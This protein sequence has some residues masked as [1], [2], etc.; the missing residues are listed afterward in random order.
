MPLQLKFYKKFL[1][2]NG[3]LAVDKDMILWHKLNYKLN[4]QNN[5]LISYMVYTGK[6][7]HY[8]AMSDTVSLPLGI[9]KMILSSKIKKRGVILP[10][11]GNIFIDIA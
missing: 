4:N 9:A 3:T 8:T 6:D 5:N 11:K 2:I 1:K 7:S 10:T